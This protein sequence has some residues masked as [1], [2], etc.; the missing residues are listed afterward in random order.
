MNA[1]YIL[2]LREIKKYLR[3]RSRIIGSLAQPVLYLVAFG[4]GFGSIYAKGSGGDYIQFLTPGIILMTVLFTA[5]FSGISLIWDRQFGFL[6]ETMVAPVSRLSIMIGKTLGGA[7]ISVIQGLLVFGITLFFGFRPFDLMLLPLTFVF[8]SLAAIFFTALGM[9]LASRLSD[10][11][12]FQ[13]IMN[14]LIMP[15]FFLSGA[16]FPL[17]GLPVI[18][19]ILT[20]IN[21]LSYAV[22]GARGTLVNIST[23]GIG[24]DLVVLVVLT[25]SI[26][27]L[28]S[29]L[30]EKIEV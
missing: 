24:V 18:M 4:Y 12:G 26:L 16:L 20:K 3:S 28:G 5:I 9:A 25:T 29:Q 2:W 7:T 1:I 15:V 22:D 14:F 17:N 13:L 6:K 10:M 23:F 30:F 27:L 8:V 21:P 11:Q 19:E